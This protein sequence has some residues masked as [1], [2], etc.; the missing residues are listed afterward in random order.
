MKIF[1][2]TIFLA[3]ASAGPIPKAYDIDA[4]RVGQPYYLTY[5]AGYFNDHYP[6]Q[7]R[8]QLVPLPSD[9]IVGQQPAPTFSGPVAVSGERYGDQQGIQLMLTVPSAVPPGTSV[10]VTVNVNSE[11]N[12]GTVV[13]VSNPVIST[14]VEA[15]PQVTPQQAEAIIVDA[16][17]TIKEPP[18]AGLLP[19]EF[20]QREPPMMFLPPFENSKD[21]PVLVAMQGEAQQQQLA[22]LLKTKTI[23]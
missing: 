19:D 23:Y 14:P 5:P 2:M 13:S 22:A 17:G 20:D 7:Q 8:Q 18:T 4:V 3:A 10:S 15:R 6:G 11:A 21:S 16:N 12:G 9:I 1:I